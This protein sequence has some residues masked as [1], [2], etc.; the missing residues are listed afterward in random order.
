MKAPKNKQSCQCVCS[1]KLRGILQRIKSSTCKD[2]RVA[3]LR[4]AAGWWTLG[5]AG[6]TLTGRLGSR[7]PLTRPA[8]RRPCAANSSAPLV[9][10]P[11]LVSMFQLRKL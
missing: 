11:G 1:A 7:R 8:S 9:P 5:L 10:Q 4:L 2:V 3:W 6:L